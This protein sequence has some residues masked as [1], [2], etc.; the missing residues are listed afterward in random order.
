MGSNRAFWAAGVAFL[1]IVPAFGHHSKAQYD[2]NQTIMLSGVVS[3]VTWTNPHVL[4][5]LDVK[6]PGAAVTTWELELAS[7]N[8]LI[9]QGWKVD[10]LKRGSYISI[11]G[12]PARDGS[13]MANAR[14]VTLAAR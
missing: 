3:K 14:K 5:F 10:S 7:P 1:L 11:S 6:E 8:G 9:S 4:V 13:H 2:E 12:N